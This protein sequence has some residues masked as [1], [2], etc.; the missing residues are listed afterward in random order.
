MKQGPRINVKISLLP[1]QI[2]ALNVRGMKA[3]APTP[4]KGLVDTGAG[5]TGIDRSLA[6][7]LGLPTIDTRGVPVQVH[8]VFAPEVVSLFM[9]VVTIVDEVGRVW[10]SGPLSLAGMNLL[11]PHGIHVL[12]GRDILSMSKLIYN[13]KDASFTLQRIG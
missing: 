8:S 6:K 2:A 10:W 3:P 12:I 7:R 1:Q 11:K 5:A 13:G 4:G 9:A